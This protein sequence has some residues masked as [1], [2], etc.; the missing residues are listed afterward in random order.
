LILERR[1][2][3]RFKRIHTEE[4]RKSKEISWGAKF[5]ILQS[6]S[7]DESKLN[8]VLEEDENEEKVLK[9]KIIKMESKIYVELKSA[10]KN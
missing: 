4:I 6:R 1:K 7:M 9:R 3:L 10:N 8:K 2:N 5:G